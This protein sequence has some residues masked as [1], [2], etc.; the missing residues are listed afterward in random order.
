MRDNQC[1]IGFSILVLLTL[2]SCAQPAQAGGPTPVSNTNPPRDWGRDL[3][4]AL[5]ATTDFFDAVGD[6]VVQV[7]QV[8]RCALGF[9]TCLL[10][11]LAW[12]GAWTL[13]N[14]SRILGLMS[15]Q[16]NARAFFNR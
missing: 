3:D 14:L 4:T 10:L 11:P 1:L 7:G 6:L 13:S 15:L 9:L 2:T 12:L 8:S 5:R 16:D